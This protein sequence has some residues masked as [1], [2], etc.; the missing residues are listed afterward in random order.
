MNSKILTING[1]V[2]DRYQLENYLEKVASD[3]VL[4]KNSDKSTYPIP[5]VKENFKF[6]TKTYERLNNDLKIGINIHPAGEW[7]LDN[8]YII[9]E[10]VKTIEKELTVEKYTKFLGIQNGMYKGTARIYVLAS[11]IVAYTDAKIESDSLKGFLEA[12]QRKKTLNMEEIWNIGLFLQIAVLEKV[13]E[14]CEKI[15]SSQMQKYRVENIVER[16]VEKKQNISFKLNPDY[17]TRTLGF[18]EM[19]YPFIEYMSYRLKRYGRQAISYLQVLEEQVNK[20]GTS[21]SEV[22]KKE[23]FDIALRKVSMGNCIKSIKEVGRIN[24]LEIFEKI[25]GVEDILKN[26]PADVYRYMDYKTKNEYRNIIKQISVK[27]KISEI[28]IAS[29]AIELANSAKLSD[30]H[31]PKKTH[32][33]YYLIAQ[34]KKELINLLFSKSSR[35]STETKMNLYIVSTW[36]L[37]AIFAS[38][39][40]LY[41]YSGT[42]N[43][44]LSIAFSIFSYLPIIEVIGK[45]INTILSKSVK[46]K[47]IPKMDFSKGI[48]KEY[49]TFVVIPTIINSKEKVKSLIHKLE[50][51]YLAN[52]SENIY[53]ALLGDCTSSSKEKIEEDEELI[54]TGL[55]EIK[56]LNEKYTGEGLPKFQFIYRNRVWNS[57]EKAFLGWERKRGLLNQFN[58]Y[59]LGNIKNPFRENTIEDWRNGKND[60]PNIKYII[61]LDADTNL[62]LESGI[63]LI[64]AMAH[65]LNKPQIDKG[66]KVVI[67]GYGIMQP[68]IGVDLIAGN[69]SMYTKIFAGLPGIDSYT[70]AISDIYQD[71]FKEGIFTGKGIYDLQTFSTVLKN[72]IPENTVL[73]HDLLE[74]SYLRCGLVSDII[75]L[76]GYPYKY[77]SDVSRHHR[78]IR[79]DWQI[80][81]WLKPTIINALNEKQLNPLNKISKYKILDN[82]RRSMVEI[83]LLISL[84]FLGIVNIFYEIKIWWIAVLLILS[85]FIPVVIDVVL[86]KENTGKQ[87]TFTPFV[88]GIKSSFIAG[89]I[90]L[91]VLPHKAYYSVNAIVKAIYR[92]NISKRGLLEWT[93]SE[94]VEKTSKTNLLSYIKLMWVNFLASTI[95][96]ALF[97]KA[98][99]EVTSIFALLLALIWICGPFIAWYIS[100][101]IQIK[102][103]NLNSEDTKFIT[104]VGEKTWDYFK[105]YMIEENNFLPP[106]NYQENRRKEVVDSTS[107]TNI[108]LA[109]LSVVSSFDLGYININETINYLEKMLN[110]I[111]KLSKWNGHLYNWY[112]IKTLEPLYPRYVSTVD[113]G[114][115]I[116]Y[117]YTLRQFV[118]KLIEKGN[119]KNTELLEII[120]KT[121]QDTDF[122]YLYE[123]EKGIF[124]IG[125]NVEE[126]KLTDSYYDLL[127]SEARQASIVAIAK[128]D[129]PSKH[130]NNLSRT[131]TCLNGYKGL[132]SWSGTAFEYLM[133]NINI[134]KYP[135]SLLDESTKFLIMSQK[136]YCK[137]LNIPWGISEAAFNLKDLN[138]NYQYKAF[139]IPWLGLKRGLGDELNITPYASVL[140]ITDE[141]KE[142]IE[143]LKKLKEE[144]MY[145][146]FGF[147]EALDYTQDRLNYGKKNAIVKTYMAH[148]QALILLSINNLLNNKVLQ[149]RFMKNPEIEAID[150]LLQERMPTDVVITKQKKEKVNK[151]KYKNYE[152]YSE[153][154][155]TKLNTELN[156]CNLISND[157]YQVCIKENGEGF[158]SYK[159]LLINRFKQTDDYNQGVFF[160]LKNIKSR[161]VWS[162]TPLESISKSEN[163]KISFTPDTAKFTRKDDNIKTKLSI[164]IAPN[165]PVEIRRLEIENEGNTEE[166]IE[167]SSVFE[168]VLSTKEQEYAHPAFN[169]LFLKYEYLQ[170]T[171]SIL[172]K[173]NK[174]GNQNAV[175]LGVNLYTENEIIGDLEYEIDKQKLCG[176]GNLKVPKMIENSIPF[177][178]TLGIVTDPVVAMRRTIKIKPGEKVSLNLL[179]TISEN[180]NDIER[181]IKD[182]QN[183]EI[184]ERTF[185]LSKARVE[186]E[187]R[188]LGI[189]AKD[190][191]KYQKLL[192]FIIFENETRKLYLKNLHKKQYS[193]SC[194]WKYGISGDLPILVVKIKD[195]NDIYVVEDLLKAYEYF[196]VKNI[197]IDLIILNEEENV[198]E[199]YVKEEVEKQ[200]Q[201][202]QLMH[203]LN[204][205]GGIFVFNTQDIEDIELFLWRANLIIDAKE[206]KLE[207]IL[208]YLEE[209]Y[210]E[211]IRIMGQQEVKTQNIENKVK[212]SSNFEKEKLKYYNEYGGFTEDGREYKICVNRE[213]RLP[214]V[215]SHVLA[216]ENFGTVITENM[217]GFT[218]SENS[219]LNRMSTWQNNS[220]LDIPSEIIYLKDNDLG[221]TWSLGLN[222]MPDENDYVITYGFGYANYK[223]RN[224]GILQEIDVFVPRED[225]VKINIIKLKNIEDK[226]RNLKFVYYIKPVLGEDELTTNSFLNLKFK[227]Q[228]NFIYMKN[229]FTDN[230]KNAISYVSCSEKISS[231]TGRKKSF[232]GKGDLTNPEGLNKV[233]L[234]FENSLGQMPCIAIQV[235]T[236]LEP[237]EYKEIALSFGNENSIEEVKKQVEK[238]SI[239]KNCNLE[240][241]KTKNKWMERINSI[242]VNTPIES[243][244]IMLNGWA[245][246]QTLAC[247]LWARSGFYQSGGAFGFRDQLQD[248]L[249]L[250]FASPEFMKKQILIHAKHQFLEGDVEH[251]WHK[252]TR[253]RYKN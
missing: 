72:Q 29:K 197:K 131:L 3:H 73:S 83:F 30:E 20:M 124:S 53:F 223:H 198:Y 190:I 220:V 150:I 211:S 140:A 57:S 162:A 4:Q 146:K 23:H 170:N 196:S 226:K 109:L 135:G 195:V 217:G 116:G 224:D 35:I 232:L 199:K 228:E 107:S 1:A 242:Q 244:N 126:N 10:S 173:R 202:R 70:N 9:E 32:I 208:H 118:I 189:K 99:F 25:N 175:Y 230:F 169:N 240:L 45:I 253:E 56:K 17:Q 6:I 93:T 95:T 42:K 164:V 136:E 231:F 183:S 184:I 185:E 67:D 64:G 247:R 24:F 238:Y 21:V 206:G 101:E 239:V 38:L 39:L 88:T 80:A 84:I 34:G 157:N 250:K 91:G 77:N 78:W 216:N 5:R 160:Y 141:P 145:S 159:N 121:I 227:E 98:P 137:K 71:N 201:N 251:W 177:S 33:G 119:L 106:D 61:T 151:I 94:E 51:F 90:N 144:G 108:G 203:K 58:E 229:V 178:R 147:Y 8:Y 193:Q 194:L 55:E 191:E 62:V 225:K 214:T 155:Y 161:K 50:V 13:R 133:P 36:G 172:I 82:L 28:Y 86:K 219:R 18:G 16:L 188:Y 128:R 66:K 130:W 48:P 92:M 142:V 156:N 7:L 2:L 204:K 52:K 105:T 139:G 176:R 31:N 11:E 246:Y 149:T 14:I 112:N 120:N 103:N 221:K 200:I 100:K 46:A 249:G 59:I 213:N 26:D 111:Q 134:R 132:V 163:F 81:R 218:W 236:C 174:R 187:N 89:I 152:Q 115:F 27:T 148:H 212:L 37:S 49:S 181:I 15:Y 241:V 97:I 102:E 166:T 69:K 75:L 40:G 123:P 22:I 180:K 237:Y 154:I 215:W 205:T 63:Q 110:T 210:K 248:T 125:F 138:S 153:R 43:I 96:I 182:Y 41:L 113:S 65:I 158:S 74:G 60:I 143:N 12:Y 85:V 252:E 127:A 19:K 171:N 168:P 76:D 209:D 54:K 79:G 44:L 243:L 87:R 233:G 104:E 114:N 186:E 245:T 117:L 122:S 207:G 47:V 129:V 68:R 192:S 165:E 179:V 234:D 222:P 235:N 167:V